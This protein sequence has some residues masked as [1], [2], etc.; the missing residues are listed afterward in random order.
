MVLNAVFNPHAPFDANSVESLVVNQCEEVSQEVKK[1]E[2]DAVNK[3]QQGD[4]MSSLNVF[5]AIVAMVPDYA[6]VYNNRAQLFRLQGD[7][8]SAMEDLNK[9]ILLSNGAGLA[10]SQAFVQR[11]LLYQLNGECELALTD[12]DAASKLG[13]VFAKSQVVAMNPYAALCNQMP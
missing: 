3:A 1:M 5:N 9:A 6:S 4:L 13:N 10:G 2:I 12:F 11:G 7:N 8:V